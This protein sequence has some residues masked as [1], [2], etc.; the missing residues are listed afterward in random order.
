MT[1][2]KQTNPEVIREFR[3][4]ATVPIPVSGEV[5]IDGGMLL[6][7]NNEDGTPLFELMQ[8]EA[9]TQRIVA[10]FNAVGTDTDYMNRVNSVFNDFPS[11]F[12][13]AVSSGKTLYAMLP[14]ILLDTIE[15]AVK[16]IRAADPE[17]K[18]VKLYDYFPLE[19]GKDFPAWPAVYEYLTGKHHPAPHPAVVPSVAGKKPTELQRP[20]DSLSSYVFGTELDD[21]TGEHEIPV[22]KAGSRDK[23]SLFFSIDFEKI[24]KLYPGVAKSLTPFDKEVYTAIW[25][26]HRVGN[27]YTTLGQIYAVLHNGGKPDKTAR[28]AIDESLNKFNAYVRFN[29]FQEI[30]HGYNYMEVD[31]EGALLPYARERVFINGQYIDDAIHILGTPPLG[32][33]ASSRGQFVTVPASVMGIGVNQTPQNLKLRD[34]LLERV[35]RRGS[36]TVITYKDMK[37][38]TGYTHTTRLK[39]AVSRFMDGFKKE[40]LV[41]SYAMGKDSVKFTRPPQKEIS[42][43][44]EK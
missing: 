3:D 34:Y 36:F 37:E 42:A 26:L 16:Q 44:A 14:V 1:E 23:I 4:P 32:N 22:E 35:Q 20:I 33:F 27:H 2:E 11:W 39:D 24:S 17:H 38:K 19:D 12:M 7:V 30:R 21:M 43:G 18:K 40:G 28:A 15:P 6:R 13:A 9:T 29:N 8:D 10:D 5:N 41:K 31:Y 25:N